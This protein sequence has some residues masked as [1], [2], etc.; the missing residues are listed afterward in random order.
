[1][2][3]QYS[4][5]FILYTV[6]I[7]A[8]LIE[9]LDGKIVCINGILFLKNDS[10]NFFN[11]L[12]G[13]EEDIEER[14]QRLNI[15]N[16]IN[17]LLLEYSI[18]Y[19]LLVFP[20]K[21]IYAKDLISTH[22]SIVGFNHRRIFKYID[23]FNFVH[24]NNIS[25]EFDSENCFIPKDTHL[26]N[27][28]IFKIFINYLKKI[29]QNNSNFLDKILLNSDELFSDVMGY[30]GDLFDMLDEF[31]K[32]H[33]SNNFPHLMCMS[34]SMVKD[35]YYSIDNEEKVSEKVVILMQSSG[36]KIESLFNLIFADY[37]CIRIHGDLHLDKILQFKADRV[38]QLITEK[39][40]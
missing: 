37:L 26:A 15:Y 38:I 31:E 34:T 32:N 14:N 4:F 27:D 21:A 18:T 16:Y 20:D 23:N 10:N 11:R 30:N 25:S 13:D 39:F 6:Y 1:M 3:L 40:L 9:Y 33:Y 12:I 19:N 17:E 29:Y 35:I 8:E 5:K 2:I 36:S 24:Y 28:E 7:M 22:F